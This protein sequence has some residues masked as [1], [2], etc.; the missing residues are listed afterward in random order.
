MVEQITKQKKAKNLNQLSG[1]ERDKI[2]KEDEIKQKENML[3]FKR[4]L[5][6]NMDYRE[7]DY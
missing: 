2:K 7:F 1:Y 3:I 6:P 5:V 4:C